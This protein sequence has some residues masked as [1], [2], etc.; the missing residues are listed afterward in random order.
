M[1]ESSIPR[2]YVIARRVLLGC[3][4]LLSAQSE[5][6]VLVGA[7]AI[8]L[9]TPLLDAGLPAST[10]DAD[11]AV[12]PDLLFENPDL[13][14]VLESASFRP[15]TNP[16]TWFSPEGVP[17]DLVVPTWRVARVKSAHCAPG[18]PER[19]NRTTHVGV[20]ASTPRQQHDG[21]SRPRPEGH[22][23]RAGQGCEPGCFGRSETDQACRA[24][25]RPKA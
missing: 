3:L 22:T 25:V 18:R 13:A 1:P 16:G 24:H 7:Q 12:D 21:T 17:V 9:Q 8:Y 2:E 19:A 23:G 4:E 10:T 20:G 6:L 11:I 14:E 15:H 5:E